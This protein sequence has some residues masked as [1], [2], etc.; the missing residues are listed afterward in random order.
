MALLQKGS[1]SRRV[2]IE[3]AIA[4]ICVLISWVTC[5]LLGPGL[6][7]FTE[8]ADKLYYLRHYYDQHNRDNWYGKRIPEVFFINCHNDDPS[9]SLVRETIANVIE[10]VM[11]MNPRQVGI[12]IRFKGHYNIGE[13][14][15]LEEILHKHKDKIV[16]AR[17]Q[18][19]DKQNRSFFDSD[20]SNFKYGYTNIGDFYTTVSYV[21]P[22]FSE[23]LLSESD[24]LN[25]N[26]KKNKGIIDF[27]LLNPQPMDLCVF[28]TEDIDALRP[29]VSD[30]IIILGD[31]DDEKDQIFVPFL[32]N[33]EER[34]PGVYYHLYCINSM[35]KNGHYFYENEWLSVL[36]CFILTIFYSIIAMLL[37]LI[38][39]SFRRKSL[40]L[41]GL[42]IKPI[43]MFWVWF[44][45]PIVLML[46]TT[47][48]G[49]VPNL[50][51]AL[52]SVAGITFLDNFF[53]ELKSRLI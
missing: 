29:L 22:S 16:I 47:W 27:S 53:E 40:Y 12:D 19:G 18:N 6:V 24:L 35:K 33:G 8:N 30:K 28:L 23:I 4:G 38:I 51:L 25:Q 32:V 39:K 14:R 41:A 9:D 5:R 43:I 46:F 52:L 7:K 26:F 50:T 45:V 15:L 34:M 10:R 36:L 49:F 11:M 21:E 2:V 1:F 48:F 20:S 3:L 37:S 44:K 17:S 42:F 31:A 13:D